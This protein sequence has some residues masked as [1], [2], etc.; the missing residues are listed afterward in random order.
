MQQSEITELVNQSIQG[1]TQAFRKLV[2]T[3]QAM[4]YSLAYRML[5][6]EDDAKDIVQETF[7]RAWK[8]L[9]TYNTKMKFTT[10]LFA[11]SSNLC[12]DSL[13]TLKRKAVF[14][15]QRIASLFVRIKNGR[16]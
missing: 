11:I 16:K 8:H 14:I 13:K 6:N 3:H 12:Y 4:I 15:M 7:I 10:W 9:S 5:C 2:E 1:N